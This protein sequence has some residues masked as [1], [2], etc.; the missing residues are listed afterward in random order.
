MEAE[1]VGV[2]IALALFSVVARLARLPRAGQ[3]QASL[4]IRRHD[5]AEK[6]VERAKTRKGTADHDDSNHTSEPEPHRVDYQTGDHAKQRNRANDAVMNLE[7]EILAGPTD[8]ANHGANLLLYAKPNNLFIRR[9][10]L[11]MRERLRA[12][13]EATQ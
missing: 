6:E 9:W 5:L 7:F 10:P 8:I 13:T 4:V 11:S 12:L 2:S 1:E 3:Q